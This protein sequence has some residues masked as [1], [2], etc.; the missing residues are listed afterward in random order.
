[1][2]SPESKRQRKKPKFS[3]PEIEITNNYLITNDSIKENRFLANSKKSIKKKPRTSSKFKNEDKYSNSFFK[4]VKNLKIGPRT[5]NA[6]MFAPIKKYEGLLLSLSSK[7]LKKKPKRLKILKNGKKKHIL[8][9]I[10]SCSNSP[11][12]KFS[13]FDFNSQKKLTKIQTKLFIKKKLKKPSSHKLLKNKENKPLKSLK[14]HLPKSPSNSKLKKAPKIFEILTLFNKHTVKYLN[15]NFLLSHL[16]HLLT[17][18]CSLENDE[19]SFFIIKEYTDYIQ[20][21]SFLILEGLME[22]KSK[23]RECLMSLKLEVV[24]IFV[25]FYNLIDGRKSEMRDFLRLIELLAKNYYIFLNLLK[26]LLSV[27]N[28]K[29]EVKMMKDFFE[30]SN[31]INVFDIQGSLFN[32]LKRNNIMIKS[33]ITKILKKKKISIRTKVDSIIKKLNNL[34]LNEGIG[35]IFQFFNKIFEKQKI[36]LFSQK[37]PKPEPG[38]DFIIQPF[39]TDTLLPPKKVQKTYSLVLDLD[40]TLIH[41]SE[42]KKGGEFFLRPYSKEFLIEMSKYYELIIFTAALKDYADWIIDR[43][44]IEKKISFRLYRRNTIKKNGVYLKDL[45]K[46]GRGLDKSLIVDNN[47]ENF[48]LQPDNG[49]Y[50]KSWYSDPEDRALEELAVVLK[51]ISLKNYGDIRDGLREFRIKYSRKTLNTH[52]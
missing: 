2:L 15:M 31:C 18:Y 6:K 49:I 7:N 29:K 21:D 20:N 4:G 25:I 48:I 43:I 17:L 5:P 8:K 41:F 22:N 19:E 33:L 52:N 32:N 34:S 13:K 24:S 36:S 46:I 51:N 45:S 39:E 40:E 11:K 12:T 37:T 30:N 1:M 14:L 27:C 10:K 44:D 47:P 38:P 50:I 42:N 28:K 35:K 3:S 26:K 9:Q 23:T 16:S